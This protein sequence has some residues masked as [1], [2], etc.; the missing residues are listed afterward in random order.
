M[1]PV[2]SALHVITQ[3]TDTLPIGSAWLSLTGIRVPRLNSIGTSARVMT[4]TG[5]RVLVVISLS[6]AMTT[7]LAMMAGQVRTT[8]QARTTGQDRTT[9]I[10]E[11]TGL[12]TR[13]GRISIDWI[14]KQRQLGRS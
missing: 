11:G 5:I 4:R 9:G 14:S 12:T 10:R 13:V 2:F 6:L 8:G 3:A 7:G 1:T